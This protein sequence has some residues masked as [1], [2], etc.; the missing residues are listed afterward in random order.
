MCPLYIPAHATRWSVVFFP[1][2]ASAFRPDFAVPSMRHLCTWQPQTLKSLSAGALATAG[3]TGATPAP[4]RDGRDGA[5]PHTKPPVQGASRHECQ[6]EAAPK[7][8]CCPIIPPTTSL[9]RS[10]IGIV[11]RRGV[12]PRKQ[13]L[14]CLL[15]ANRR[16]FVDC[17]FGILGA[18]PPLKARKGTTCKCD[19]YRDLVFYWNRPCHPRLKR[20]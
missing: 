15:L 14:M 6:V 1:G 16:C 7:R 13:C 11:G 17:R 18:G 20:E 4:I 3:Q 8:A 10:P 2:P 12:L 9:G 5:C 19:V